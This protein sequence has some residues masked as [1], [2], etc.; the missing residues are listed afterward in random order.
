[1]AEQAINTIP[2]APPP[3]SKS[4]KGRRRPRQR[5]HPT[6]RRPACFA[7]LPPEL[8]GLIAEHVRALDIAQPEP[9]PIATSAHHHVR[10]R[11]L[12]EGKRSTKEL[13][14]MMVEMFRMTT[15]CRSGLST[16]S[17]IN[18]ECFLIARPILWQHLDL[19]DRTCTSLLLFLRDILPR[20]ASLVKSL[21]FDYDSCIQRSG[22][23][24]LDESY[25][26][27]QEKRN[28]K[29]AER[30][31]NLKPHRKLAIRR[32]RTPG[33]FVGEIIKQLVNLEK[34]DFT[35]FLPEDY[36]LNEHWNERWQ[37]HAFQALV[38]LRAPLRSLD[39]FVDWDVKD[40][41]INLE[42]LL[43][44]SPDLET[45]VLHGATT[46]GD[47]NTLAY[48]GLWATLA[49]LDKLQ[50][51]TLELPV[52][53]DVAELDIAW[54]L[55]SLILDSTGPTSP[56]ALAKFLSKFSNTLKNLELRYIYNGMPEGDDPVSTS[57]PSLDKITFSLPRLTR[58]AVAN[59]SYDANSFL[60]PFSK[61]PLEVLRIE[62]CA[63]SAGEHVLAALETHKATLK[64]VQLFSAEYFMVLK[65]EDRKKIRE[66]CE[67]SGVAY[68][69][70]A[71]ED[72]D[73]EETDEEQSEYAYDSDVAYEYDYSDEYGDEDDDEEE[74]EEVGTTGGVGEEGEWT[75]EEGSDD[76]LSAALGAELI[77]GD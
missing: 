46:E 8:K 29:V 39:L 47:E 11:L 14:K 45:L 4:S 1:M 67:K 43:E 19:G 36:D 30:M 65:E 73:G 23:T 53:H 69:D 55:T 60:A 70:V 48:R 13:A 9:R 51:L 44:G 58:L 12:K 63:A 31:A 76:G 22:L 57:T 37:D 40:Q 66:W 54:P 50:R 27:T 15:P 18:R 3:A 16:F 42:R 49:G 52:P 10:D 56:S 64:K 72:S 41:G 74:E 68:E 62:D 24:D 35:P 26:S 59:F 32:L 17:L 2:N 33:V 20:H 77:L 6:P 7:A 34:V 5:H 71:H 25:F 75:D 61:S 38:A 21:V 28:A